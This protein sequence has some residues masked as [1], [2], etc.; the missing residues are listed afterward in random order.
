MT[1]DRQVDLRSDTVTRP[2]DEMRDAMATAEVGDDV[3][4][5]DPEV[6]RLEREAADRL[7]KEAA[8][9]VPSGTMGNQV[10]LHTWMEPGNEI[11]LE[12]RAHIYNHERGAFASISGLVPRPVSGGV[13]GRLDPEKMRNAVQPDAYYL[14]DTSLIAVES[15]H[16]RA[17]GTVYSRDR[18][19]SI[20]ALADELDVPVHLDGAR[21]FN[22]AQFLGVSPD[23]IADHADSVMFCLSKG[24]SAPVGSVLAGPESFIEEA[25]GVRKMMGGGMR[26]SGI[27]AAA[28]RV[29]LDQMMDRLEHDHRRASIIGEF[30]REHENLSLPAGPVETNIVIF[31]IN[32]DRTA[33]NLVSE[34]ETR[35]IQ[36]GA[37]GPE[38]VRF[39][40]HR[41]MDDADIRYTL[42]SLKDILP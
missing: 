26:Q 2:T 13:D 17:G 35:G 19:E 3:Y 39:V 42:N 38:E 11:L 25:L 29:A 5:E 37:V 18:L 21:L 12:E 4:R 8:L 30:I 1:G 7:G 10:S 24:L 14:S 40:V 27:L 22:A 20:R 9:F 28:G 16:N 15:P 23:Q 34:L 31:R 6:Q 36:S 32:G 41:H 33:E